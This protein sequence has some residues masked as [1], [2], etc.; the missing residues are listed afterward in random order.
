MDM[1]KRFS[2]KAKRH[3]AESKMRT[4]RMLQKARYGHGSGP[5]TISYLPG[6]GPE[7]K[8]PEKKT[9]FPFEAMINGRSVSVHGIG[10]I[11]RFDYLGEPEE[12]EWWEQPL[13]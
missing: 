11:E 12:L 3:A 10:E 13:S 7:G 2:K 6:F 9:K 5:V 1:S 8:L 4:K